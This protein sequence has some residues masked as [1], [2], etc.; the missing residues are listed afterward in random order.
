[1][2]GARRACWFSVQQA[3][4]V[5]QGLKSPPYSQHGQQSWSISVVIFL[6]DF[7]DITLV[8]VFVVLF[9]LH[10]FTHTQSTSHAHSV[11]M[12]WLKNLFMIW[13]Q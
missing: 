4:I 2:L 6:C 11:R 7:S 13:S 9:V 10:C 3:V 5:M 1:V 12:Y 8:A